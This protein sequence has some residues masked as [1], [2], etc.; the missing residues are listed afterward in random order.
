MIE[1]HHLVDIVTPKEVVLE[2]V[3]IIEINNRRVEKS[4]MP[5]PK[6]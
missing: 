1:Q 4:I 5:Y 2:S 3:S 6:Q